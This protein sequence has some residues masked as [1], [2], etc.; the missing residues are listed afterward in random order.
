MTACDGKPWRQSHVGHTNRREGGHLVYVEQ[1]RALWTR[2]IVPFETHGI[3]G[4]AAL[5][6][7]FDRVRVVHQVDAAAVVGVAFAHFARAVLK[8]HDARA[9]LDDESLPRAEEAGCA[10]VCSAVRRH[11]QLAAREVRACGS[12]KTRFFFA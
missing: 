8:R 10:R 4:L 7:A 2:G 9:F 1:I 6:L 3:I 12:L 11:T 5:D